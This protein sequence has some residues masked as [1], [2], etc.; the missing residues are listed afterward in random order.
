MLSRD[1]YKSFARRTLK[2]SPGTPKDEPTDT[3]LRAEYNR[4]E[5]TFLAERDRDRSDVDQGLERERRFAVE[6]TKL[7]R[8]VIWAKDE[9]LPVVVYDKSVDE[10]K[11]REM[12]PLGRDLTELSV[13]SQI[14]DLVRFMW[15]HTRPYKTV[16]MIMIMS[17]ARPFQNAVLAYV[18]Q[19]IQKDPKSVPLWLYFMGFYATVFERFLYWWYEMW[20]PLNSQRVQLRSVLLTRRVGL[21]DSHPL[22]YKWPA[23][24][25]TGLLKD[26]DDVVNGIW[27]SFLKLIDDL[28]TMLY[29][30]VLCFVNL[31]ISHQQLEAQGTS[32]L[33]YGTYVGIFLALG[34]VT[35]SLPFVWFRMFNEKIQECEAMV[36]DGQALYMSASS[37][38]I[39]MGSDGWLNKSTTVNADIEKGEG[40]SLDQPLLKGSETTARKSFRVYGLTTF[41][42]FFLRLAWSTNYKLLTQ[43]WGPLIAYFLLTSEDFGD[44]F[45]LTSTLIVLLSLRDITALSVKLLDYLTTM[46]RGCNVLVDV[47][48]LLN[49][50][51]DSP[52]HKTEEGSVKVEGTEEEEEEVPVDAAASHTHVVKSKASGT[53]KLP[54]TTNRGEGRVIW[55]VEPAQEVSQQ[56][57]TS[58]P[59]SYNTHN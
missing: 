11:E 56:E 28:M 32:T 34:I 27:S 43:V 48:E 30:L 19:E 50:E 10:Y 59:S 22:A 26:V 46:G 38:A 58:N 52:D 53:Q 18:A 29:L 20:V 23:G 41:R 33:S 57:S 25:F 42:S 35:I 5:A 13:Y 12:W 40:G 4:R 15:R 31:A 9:G 16:A 47:A 14:W 3:C 7:S 1:E 55:D 2:A 24:R 39:T 36:R 45:N 6:W 51:M 54:S 17:L 21:P 8:N 49:A 44:G 37:D